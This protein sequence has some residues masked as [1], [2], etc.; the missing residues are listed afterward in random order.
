MA[1][2]TELE[3]VN[4]IMSR[5]QI[6]YGLDEL[7]PILEDL[8]D[9]IAMDVDWLITRLYSAWSIIEAYQRELRELQK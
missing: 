4:A 8:L 3:R 9:G 5:A 6:I 1:T 7:N 2:N